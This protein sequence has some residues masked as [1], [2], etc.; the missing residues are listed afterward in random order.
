MVQFRVVGVSIKEWVATSPTG[1][2]RQK[3]WWLYGGVRG[4]DNSWTHFV[5]LKKEGG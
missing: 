2:S 5:K 4:G 1:R 3:R